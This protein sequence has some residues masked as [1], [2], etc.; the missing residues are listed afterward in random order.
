MIKYRGSDPVRG[1]FPYCQGLLAPGAQ[2]ARRQMYLMSITYFHYN[3][4]T[5][6]RGLIPAHCGDISSVRHTHDST[7]YEHQSICVF[8]MAVVTMTVAEA[9]EERFRN[10]I[11]NNLVPYR[12]THRNLRR[13]THCNHSLQAIVSEV[14]G[15]PFSFGRC[16]MD[17]LA[18]PMAAPTPLKTYAHSLRSLIQLPS[19][20]QVGKHGVKLGGGGV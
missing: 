18:R 20:K 16:Q 4:A 9:T 19:F 12:H 3:R 11:S 5:P 14:E 8:W 7:A 17:V 15:V 2:F 13:A 6:F 10:L 1:H